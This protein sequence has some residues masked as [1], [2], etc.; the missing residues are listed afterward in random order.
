MIGYRNS[1]NIGQVD[2][3]PSRDGATYSISIDNQTGDEL[4]VKYRNGSTQVVT[5][6]TRSKRNVVVID[7][8]WH[9]STASIR[10]LKDSF[11]TST[12]YSEFARHAF[13]ALSVFCG[14]PSKELP[15]L[16]I[17]I[18]GHDIEHS[19]YLE[20][21]DILIC[22]AKVY[23]EV[24][25][26]FS[27]AKRFAN[28]GNAARVLL[29]QVAPKST[30]FAVE[31]VDNNPCRK[32]PDQYIALGEV[33]CH[34]PVIH[35]A[36]STEHGIIITRSPTADEKNNNVRLTHIREILTFENA[37]IK[38]GICSTIEEAKAYGNSRLATEVKIANLQMQTKQMDAEINLGKKQHDSDTFERNKETDAL[39]HKRDME[40]TAE[41]WRIEK[42]KLEYDSRMAKEK[43]RREEVKF[44]QETTRDEIKNT[45]EWM[46][47]IALCVTGIG[48]IFR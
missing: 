5:N 18:D 47:V 44:K 31:A 3:E 9:G 40:I 30:V 43:A 36:S 37:R 28:G 24:E 13:K 2:S 46:R 48:A 27:P 19:L 12:A 4:F 17:I 34:I 20:D 45:M 35:D 15:M 7:I 1:N 21:L 42:E 26:P 41:K 8:T 10:F 14:N 38:Y 32:Y 16:R 33:V 11:E 25:H 22:N 6:T 39:K 29:E 23:K